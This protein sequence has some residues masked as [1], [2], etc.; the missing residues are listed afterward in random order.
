VAREGPRGSRG[1]QRPWYLSLILRLKLYTDEISAVRTRV[2][3]RRVRSKELEGK[4]G[5]EEKEATV[6]EKRVIGLARERLSSSLFQTIPDI[7]A[8]VVVSSLILVSFVVTLPVLANMKIF[9]FVF[10]IRRSYNL[11]LM[12]EIGLQIL[13]QILSQKRKL[14]HFEGS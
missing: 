2:A 3:T 13:Q 5:S 7:L 8:T 4:E 14:R 9:S 10:T 11:S 6:I 12:L 1:R